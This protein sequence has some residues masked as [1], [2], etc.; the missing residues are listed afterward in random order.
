V[1][2]GQNQTMKVRKHYIN[3]ANPD[4]GIGTGRPAKRAKIVPVANEA[5]KSMNSESLNFN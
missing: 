4:L 1:Q 5:R 2:V 3:I